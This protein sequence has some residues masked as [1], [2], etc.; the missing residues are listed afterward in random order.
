MLIDLWQS[1]EIS[2]ESASL[3]CCPCP[4]VKPSTVCMAS[5]SS[6]SCPSVVLD[7]CRLHVLPFGP[8]HS[9]RRNPAFHISPCVCASRAIYQRPDLAIKAARSGGRPGEHFDR[10]R[11]AH[12]ECIFL[13]GFV[14]LRGGL[15]LYL[16]ASEKSEGVT[17]DSQLEIVWPTIDISQS[18]RH[19]TAIEIP[20]FSLV[21]SLGPIYSPLIVEHSLCVSSILGSTSDDITS[22]MS[23]HTLD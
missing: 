12:D 22:F 5:R 4:L 23:A 19:R 2:A 8:S 11:K 3:A 18:E 17:A 1:Q 15:H 6:R 16:Y 9:F 21:H 10:E 7:G 14:C 13:R 20:S